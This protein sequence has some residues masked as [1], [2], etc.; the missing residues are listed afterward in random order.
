M[1]R[2]CL[3]LQMKFS[4]RWRALY[5]SLSKSRCSLR[6]LLGGITG[7]FPAAKSGSITRSS[8]SKALSANT[9]SAFICGRV[10]ALQIMRL[11]TGQEE[12]KRVAQRV[13]REMDFC[14]QPTFAAP[15]RLIF[16]VFFW[17]PALCW[18]ARTMVLSI[19]AYSKVDRK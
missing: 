4:M 3:S 15:D 10:G 9:V 5:S 14:A 2:N 8:A 1:A 16:A 19:M 7:V 13:D 17:A 6:L 12:R 11:T 18:W